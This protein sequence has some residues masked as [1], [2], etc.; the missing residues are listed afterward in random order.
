MTFNEW[1]DSL[2]AKVAGSWN[3]HSLLPQNLDFF[4]F[5]SSIQGIVGA[6][7]QA[8]YAAANA[9]QDALARLRVSQ[10]MK[11]VSLDLGAVETDGF[12]S[13]NHEELELLRAQNTYRFMS[14]AEL[15]V[16]MEYICDPKLE[17]KRPEDAQVVLGLN[18]LPANKSLDPPGTSWAE[19][20]FFR[21]IR[22]QTS[23][24]TQ[25]QG[26]EGTTGESFRAQL[27][28][29]ET[30]KDATNLI[31][32]ALIHRLASSILRLEPE[33]V[34]DSRSIQAYGVDSLQ[35]MELRSWFLRFFAADIPTFEILGATSLAALAAMIAERSGLRKKS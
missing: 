28:A 31:T 1:K 34:D 20:P 16:L 17:I 18:L 22:R 13:E 2:K 25:A 10:G 29:A 15:L 33:D 3:L 8:N 4:I 6:R 9:F 24:V 32:K 5:F 23:V 27:M 26:M 21:P 30:V 14:R 11:S 12:L 19:N 35:T 7:G